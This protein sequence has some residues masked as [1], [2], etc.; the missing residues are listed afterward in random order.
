MIGKRRIEGETE[1]RRRKREKREG[2][3]V[4]LGILSPSYSVWGSGLWSGCACTHGGYS[5]L[6]NNP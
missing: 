1:N 6:I 3:N 5:P 4:V 2:R